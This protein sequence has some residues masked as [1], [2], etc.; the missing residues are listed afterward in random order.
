MESAPVVRIE[1]PEGIIDEIPSVVIDEQDEEAMNSEFLLGVYAKDIY[2]FLRYLEVNQSIRKGYLTP[3]HIM[4][5]NMR[6]L[7]V[8]WLFEVQQSFKLL[9]ETIQ[10]A[11]ALLD[12]F[13]QDNPSVPKNE[14]QLVGV[15]C[16][17][18]ASKYE[19]MYPPGK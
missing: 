6:A 19:E 14:L 17:F 5:Q 13:M 12:R 8:D 10:L 9:N 16:I 15:G 4:T 1:P 11:I 3:A 2:K 7:L 18:L